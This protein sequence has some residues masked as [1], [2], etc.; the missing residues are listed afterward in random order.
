MAAER[1]ISPDNLVAE[2][3]DVRPFVVR[4]GADI[5]ANVITLAE[6]TSPSLTFGSTGINGTNTTVFFT[7]DRTGRHKVKF[8]IQTESGETINRVVELRVIDSSCDGGRRDY[9]D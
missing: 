1:L 7:A 2:L 3:G 5:G 8:A 4:W 9:G 6:T